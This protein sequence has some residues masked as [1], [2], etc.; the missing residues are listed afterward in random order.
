MCRLINK[1]VDRYH[2]SKRLYGDKS[3]EN[4]RKYLIANGVC[5]PGGGKIQ[6]P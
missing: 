2:R 6:I 1:L 5:V 3:P 4:F